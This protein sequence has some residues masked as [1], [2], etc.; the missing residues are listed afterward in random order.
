MQLNLNMGYRVD[1]YN[2]RMYAIQ[3]LANTKRTGYYDVY[4]TNQIEINLMVEGIEYEDA[5]HQIDS[6][7]Q[8]GHHIVYRLSS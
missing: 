1:E 6:K 4:T 2:P 8:I 5:K 7:R 3:A